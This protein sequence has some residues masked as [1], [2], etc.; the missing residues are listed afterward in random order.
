MSSNT[1][2]V[3]EQG[4]V[5]LNQPGTVS[6]DALLLGK[7]RKHLLS[8][9]HGAY[10][11]EDI[12]RALKLQSP[13]DPEKQANVSAQIQ[14]DLLLLL[15]E[16]LIREIEPLRYK[17][18]LFFDQERHIEHAF[19]GGMGSVHYSFFTPVFRLNLGVLSLF[20][21]FNEKQKSWRVSVADATIGKNYCLVHPLC[22]G[23]HCFGTNPKKVEGQSSWV[24]DG[25]YID[26]T[27]VTVTLCNDRI[28]LEDH[29]TLRG[30]RIDHFTDPGLS[31]YLKVSEEFLRTTDPADR[32]DIL[33]RGRFVLERL[34]HR[35]E[36]YEA[37]FF[38]AV[39]DFLLIRNSD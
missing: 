3:G 25:K 31:S 15:N 27:H 1:S 24:I 32:K 17:T 21:L 26:K 20:F 13:K 19:I 7:I 8:D 37:A 9:P 22:E 11:A 2:A 4:K 38:S 5:S 18:R 28:T 10:S 33:K 14:S 30:T 23:A 36:N 35:Y 12:S 6:S 34:L 29:R 16:G 39:I